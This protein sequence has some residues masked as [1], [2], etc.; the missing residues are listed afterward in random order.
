[1]MGNWVGKFALG[2]MLTVGGAT[3]L[4]AQTSAVNNP[5]RKFMTPDQARRWLE[6]MTDALDSLP[7]FAPYRAVLQ[8]YF[9]DSAVFL[10]NR[11]S[12]DSLQIAVEDVHS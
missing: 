1:M 4:P 10:V 11:E 9:A 5:A 7:A 8:R 12:S 3:A 2:L 6:A